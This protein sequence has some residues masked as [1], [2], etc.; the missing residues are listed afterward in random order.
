MINKSIRHILERIERRFFFLDK[1]TTSLNIQPYQFKHSKKRNSKTKRKKQNPVFSIQIRHLIH[2]KRASF[3]YQR[4]EQERDREAIVALN[5]ATQ[6]NNEEK[7]FQLLEAISALCLKILELIA[8]RE[9]ACPWSY[10]L[11]SVSKY[12]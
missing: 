5:L 4:R 2:E 1:F 6:L 10:F 11:N 8:A 3:S 9:R 12:T 7:I